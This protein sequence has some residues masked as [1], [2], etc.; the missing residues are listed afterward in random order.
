[1]STTPVT[2]YDLKLVNETIKNITRDDAISFTEFEASNVVITTYPQKNPE[3]TKIIGYGLNIDYVKDGRKSK[4]YLETPPSSHAIYGLSNGFKN[5]GNYAIVIQKK[6]G[7]NVLSL[8]DKVL[9][10]MDKF[11]SELQKL[12]QMV[13]DFCIENYQLLFN[14]DHS[15]E[16]RN[17]MMRSNFFGI[18]KDKSTDTKSYPLQMNLKCPKFK[19]TNI[20]E[21]KFT[22]LNTMDKD[23]NFSPMTDLSFDIMSELIKPHSYITCDFQV[24]FW[25][26]SGNFGLKCE[27]VRFYILKLMIFQ[28]LERISGNHIKIP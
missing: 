18:V 23:G 8:R 13:K 6:T 17:E 14:K 26:V 2:K 27:V 22:D 11:Y 3:K 15:L 9:K 28:N 19:N 1:M 4:L 20:P 7:C 25:S 5:N 12:E 16:M 10:G 21:L 24:I